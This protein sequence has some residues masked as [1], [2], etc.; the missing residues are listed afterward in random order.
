MI[1]TFV[2]DWATVRP[3]AQTV[4]PSRCRPH[5]RAPGAASSPGSSTRSAPPA[6]ANS[7]SP[8][9]SSPQE[10]RTLSVLQSVVPEEDLD[11]AVT[12]WANPVLRRSTAA[13]RV[14]KLL[15][16]AHTA[17]TRLADA[18]ALGTELMAF[19]LAAAEYTRTQ[20][21]RRTGHPV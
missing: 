2:P 5:L 20:E 6:S 21:L 7:S 8:A 18:S 11:A 19:V 12:A 1:N 4:T 14:T 3:V 17:A 16:N 9:G 13:L 15:L 10:A